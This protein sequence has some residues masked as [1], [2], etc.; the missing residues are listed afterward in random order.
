MRFTCADQYFPASFVDDSLSVLDLNQQCETCVA[1]FAVS[2][3]PLAP[4]NQEKNVRKNNTWL[5]DATI[6]RPPPMQPRQDGN[7]SNYWLR[8]GA[9]QPPQLL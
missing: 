7:P 9:I 6:R 5:R 4:R 1:I 8:N 2:G 3:E